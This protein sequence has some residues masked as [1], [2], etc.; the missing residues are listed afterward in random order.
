MTCIAKATNKRYD[1]NGVTWFKEWALFDGDREFGVMV[2]NKHWDKSFQV[3]FHSPLGKRFGIAGVMEFTD[4]SE[5]LAY[6]RENKDQNKTYTMAMVEHH[7]EKLREYRYQE[8]MSND[9]FYVSGMAA[10][11]D[12]RKRELMRLKSALVQNGI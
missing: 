9:F 8:E 4:V 7:L 11:Y 5:A 2:W 12:A 3:M 6:A 1:K 10:S